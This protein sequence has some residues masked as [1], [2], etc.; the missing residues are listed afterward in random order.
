[1]FTTVTPVL[2]SWLYLRVHHDTGLQ[3]SLLF[4]L[5]KVLQG[6]LLLRSD[7]GAALHLSAIRVGHIELGINLYLNHYP[8]C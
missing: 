3:G 4:G 6:S 1:M 7:Q 8:F 5:I 2:K